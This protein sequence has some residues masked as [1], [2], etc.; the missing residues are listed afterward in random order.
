[1]LTNDHS[2]FIYVSRRYQWTPQL[3]IWA[4]IEEVMLVQTLA[5]QR[6]N[7]RPLL[8]QGP[9]QIAISPSS[10]LRLRC[11]ILSILESTRHKL[12]ITHGLILVPPSFHGWEAFLTPKAPTHIRII[13]ALSPTASQVPDVT[14]RSPLCPWCFGHSSWRGARH[15]PNSKPTCILFLMIS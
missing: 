4:I 1:M 6:A 3:P 13:W 15:W 8:Y 5:V 7:P 11:Y 14:L 12:R 9:T 2:I 10:H